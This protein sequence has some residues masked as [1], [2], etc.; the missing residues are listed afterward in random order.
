MDYYILVQLYINEYKN[1]IYVLVRYQ[2][3]LFELFPF[4]KKMVYTY[5]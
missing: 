2:N 3:I 4:F 1:N 5:Q